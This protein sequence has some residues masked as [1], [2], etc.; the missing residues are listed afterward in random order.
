M[1]GAKG[2]AAVF[3][4]VVLAFIFWPHP[5]SSYDP[6]KRYRKTDSGEFV[7]VPRSES[8]SKESS[9]Y[10]QVEGGSNYDI[11]KNAEEE[12]E[13]IYEKYDRMFTESQRGYDYGS[14]NNKGPGTEYYIKGNI[15]FETGERIYH[16]P[17]DMYYDETVI[18]ESAGERWFSS[19]AEAQAAG[20][21]HAYC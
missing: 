19:E 21:R 2:I 5:D 4:V 20:W 8:A 10:S 11:G 12:Y 18:D 14:S 3:L 13:Q 15:S 1:N 17:G 16:L 7:E 6:D 9:K